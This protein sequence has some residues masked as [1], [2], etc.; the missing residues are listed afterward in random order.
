[1]LSVNG[2]AFS[3]SEILKIDTVTA[4]PKTQF[5][6]IVDQAF[7]FHPLA[8]SHLGEQVNRSL[9]QYA[10]ADAFLYILAAAIFNHDGVD[11]VQ[12]QKVR[13]H[14]TGWPR[15]DNPDLGAL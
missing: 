1:M 5:D 12:I 15:A 6:P 10:G 14:E 8:H 7:G 3:A 13:Q 4:S 2:D 9:L 11:P